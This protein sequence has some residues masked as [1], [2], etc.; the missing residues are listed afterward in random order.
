MTCTIL[1]HGPYYC[2]YD[3]SR[4]PTGHRSSVSL[5]S[6]EIRSGLT[7]NWIGLQTQESG[8]YKYTFNKIADQRYSDPFKLSP[9]LVLEQIVHPTPS[10]K[11]QSKSRYAR[12]VCVGDTFDSDDIGAIWLELKGQ[13]PFSIRLGLKHKSELYGKTIQLDDINTNKFKL[14]LTDEVSTPGHYDLK[15]LDVK[16]GNGC[17]DQASGPE[18]VLSIEAQDIATIVPA[19]SCAEHCVGDTLEY[20]LS[21]VGPFTICTFIFFSFLVSS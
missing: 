18:S 5:G 20:S 7:K 12:T 6:N 13:A 19:E 21:G 15:L 10:V 11:F 9:P 3:Q 8:K 17:S 1:G 14:E 2:S 4:I 16:D